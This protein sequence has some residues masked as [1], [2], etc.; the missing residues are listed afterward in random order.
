MH[1]T[2]MFCLF[3][4]ITQR[5]PSL[6]LYVMFHII[7]MNFR[8]SPARLPLGLLYILREP[9]DQALRQRIA[10]HE[11]RPHHQNLRRQALKQPAYALRLD[12]IAKHRHTRHTRLEVRVLYPCLDNVKWSSDGNGGNGTS[13]GGDEVL[14]PGCAAIV[15]YAEKIFRCYRRAKQLDGDG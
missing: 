15:S 12:Q 11:L 3:Y 1:Q 6:G 9:W 2:G 8:C 5:N 7:T 10:E 14:C 13:D 4:K